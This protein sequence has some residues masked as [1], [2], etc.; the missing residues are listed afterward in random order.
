MNR[1]YTT[2][3]IIVL[4]L[5]SVFSLQIFI[6]T[7]ESMAPTYEHDQYVLVER[8][9]KH[10]GMLTRGEVIVFTNPHDRE[11]ITMKRVIG[12][13]NETVHIFDTKV[14]IVQNDGSE[15]E[16][17]S[18]TVIGVG[19]GSGNGSRFEIVLGAE[20]YF[21]LGDNRGKSTDSRDWG[22]VQ[23]SDVIGKPIFSF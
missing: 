2:L 14:V 16:F 10:F 3:T 5:F 12:L 1:L 17:G 4:I 9:S 18:G 21:V 22:A 23:L 19:T 11:H 20:D 15:E 13:P 6:I 7:G 8:V